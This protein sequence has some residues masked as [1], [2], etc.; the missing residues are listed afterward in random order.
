MRGTI[1]TELVWPTSAKGL[2]RRSTGVIRSLSEKNA[3]RA[4]CNSLPTSF[5]PRFAGDEL[6]DCDHTGRRT[7]NETCIS[8]SRF[9]SFHS[10]L[11]LILL[12]RG[13]FH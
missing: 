2:F 9:V 5:M 3:V 11:Y 1:Y 13:L 12:V 8:K 6:T 7:E 4:L 10:Q